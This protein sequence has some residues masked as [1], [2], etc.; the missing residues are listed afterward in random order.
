MNATDMQPEAGGRLVTPLRGG[1]ALAILVAAAGLRIYKITD[2]SVHADE[3][4]TWLECIVGYPTDQYR[5]YLLM[6]LGIAPVHATA[7]LLG[8]THLGLR[9][10]PAICGLLAVAAA[11]GLGWRALGFRF[12]AGVATLVA[13][14]P[15]HIYLSQYGRFY[16]PAFLYMTVGLF[17][18]IIG[19]RERKRGWL[20]LAAV[21]LAATMYGHTYGLF[22]LAA[23]LGMMLVLWIVPPLRPRE[24]RTADVWGVALLT[25]VLLVPLALLLM[26]IVPRWAGGNV[27]GYSPLHTLL[28]LLNNVTLPMVAAAGVGLLAVL[29][30]RDWRGWLLAAVAVIPPVLVIAASQFVAARHDYAFAGAIGIYALAAFGI[31]HYAGRFRGGVLVATLLL[32]F[33]QAPSIASYYQTGNRF[34]YRRAFEYVQQQ[35]RPGDLLV[36]EAPGLAEYYADESLRVVRWRDWFGAGTPPPAGRTWIVAIVGRRGMI[37]ESDEAPMDDWLHRHARLA[38]QHAPRRFD[39]YEHV[40]QVWRRAAAAPADGGR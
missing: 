5:Y 17:A 37:S 30:R 27:W 8:P 32:V 38:W 15:W 26:R 16:A 34:D 40:I 18:L 6:P 12:G 33:M 36:T 22:A 19:L 24:W 39:Y 11:L 21:M 10:G 1:L 28:G 31:V 4:A 13:T 29:F 3:L 35:W 2:F 25:A 23:A 9:L 7:E 14:A 20:T